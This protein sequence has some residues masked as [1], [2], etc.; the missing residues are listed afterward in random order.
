MFKTSKA[1]LVSR[2]SLTQ[3]LAITFFFLFASLCGLSAWADEFKMNCDVQG[4]IPAM[5]DKS[6]APARVS[7]LI[8]TLGNNIFIQIV[9]ANPYDMKVS[10][11]ATKVMSGTNL[12]NPKHLGV[13]AKNKDTGQES[14][15]IIDQKTVT[16]TGYNDIEVQKQI[17]R[18]VI[19][20]QCILPN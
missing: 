20:G 19:N 18:L 8:Q 10:T 5:P 14:Q 2:S 3:R 17:V 11:L 9:G 12:T 6:I 15:L 7:L 4:T 1:L 13:K 16:L